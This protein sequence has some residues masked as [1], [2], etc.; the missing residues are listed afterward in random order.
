[1]PSTSIEWVRRGEDL[2]GPVST[3]KGRHVTFDTDEW[4]S[5]AAERLLEAARP[6]APVCV[7]WP[8]V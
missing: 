4:K 5:F 2:V 1:M 8:W 3:G 6:W 7:S